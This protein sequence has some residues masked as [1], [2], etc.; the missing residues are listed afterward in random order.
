MPGNVGVA[1]GIFAILLALTAKEIFWSQSTTDA[2]DVDRDVRAP[3]MSQYATPTIKFLFCYSWGYRNA[4]EQMAQAIKDRYPGLQVEGGNFP[5]PPLR[6]VTAQTLSA[7]KFI[8]IIVLVSGQN[9]FAYLNVATPEAYNWAMDNRVYACMM[10]FFVSNMIETQLVSTGAFEIDFNGM[11]MW[12]K[13]QTG[14]IPTG[15]ELF[16]MIESNM[17]M[18]GGGSSKFS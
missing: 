17:E 4:F 3:K 9:P 11:R 1:G 12:S 5:P 13:I 16:Q 10:V 15:P 18:A 6:S 2:V 14:R 7:L 8:L